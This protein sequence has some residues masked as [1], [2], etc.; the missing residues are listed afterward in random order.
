[1]VGKNK[2]YLTEIIEL[3]RTEDVK[4]VLLTMPGSSYYRELL[5]KKQL[6]EMRDICQ[7]FASAGDVMYLD[8]LDATSF[9][10]EDFRD[11]DHLNLQG[12]VKLSQYLESVIS[13]ELPSR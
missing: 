6:E 4:V 2:E 3:A 10:A 9:V 12:A 8:L 1:M 13:Q 5:D 7:D 11:G